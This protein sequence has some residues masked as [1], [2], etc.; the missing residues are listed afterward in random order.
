MPRGAWLVWGV[1]LVAYLVGVLQ[2]T[3][4]GVAGIAAADRFHASASVLA[5]FAVLQ[6][7]VYA[8][9]QV[10]VGVLMDRV[11]PKALIAAGAFTMAVGQTVLGLSHELTLAIAG[12]VLVGAGDAMTFVCVLRVV[13]AWFPGRL[14]PLVT[15][16]TGMT[17]Q[18]GQILSAVPLV[19]LLH[20]PGW[21]TTYLSAAALGVLAGALV[22]IGLRERPPGAGPAPRS[23]SGRAV[24]RQLL[25]AL[26]HPGT[27]LGFLTHMATQFSAT[28]FALLW[29]FPF[30]V[31][32]E[33]RTPAEAGTLLT[34]LVVV[35]M[36]TGPFFGRFVARHPLRRSWLVLAIIGT[37]AFWWTVLLLWPGRA[38]L[39]LL[40]V[41]VVATAAGGPGSMIGF[42]YART[43]NPAGRVGSATGI[44]NVGG[45]LAS[46]VTMLV[47]GVVLDASGTGRGSGRTASYS[48][49]AFRLAW[50]FQ[51]VVW[52]LGVVGLLHAR[53]QVRARL[54]RQGVVV[55]P[56]R[57]AI[58]RERRARRS[59]T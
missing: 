23:P 20:G 38:P 28:V 16:L 39:W 24:R 14:V 22:L 31:A 11:G 36:I 33:G 10:P 13:T 8:G 37:T 7:L 32:G 6:L 1:A 51:Y 48:L 49:D 3:S 4:L 19:A 57:E 15:Q 5:T 52:G 21:T 34:L 55:P 25:A 40:V 44:V 59:R 12:R 29:G 53:K 45:F 2:R 27:R 43:F 54:A 46:L 50:S 18:L 47:I 30:L 35:A 42:D 56:I 17:G 58:A 41:T 9:L 26:R